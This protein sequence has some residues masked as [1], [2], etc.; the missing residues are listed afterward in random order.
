VRLF[1]ATIGFLIFAPTVVAFTVYV[2]LFVRSMLRNWTLEHL[3][4]LLFLWQTQIAA[5][6]AIA[7]ALIGSAVVLHQTA[8]VRRQ[9]DERRERRSAALWAVLPLVLMELIDYATSCAKILAGLLERSSTGVHVHQ[10]GLQ[11]PPL[12]DGL[13]DR[14]A[15]LIEAIESGHANPLIILVRRLQIQH[16]RAREIQRRA[17]DQHGSIVL[18][19]NLIHGLIGAAEIYA[20]CANLLSYA[21]GSVDIVAAI[22]PNDV[23]TALSALSLIAGD[24]SDIKEL[25][26]EIDRIAATDPNGG[27]PET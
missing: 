21:R 25:I 2:R 22:S 5:A 19:A 3:I 15:E 7:A 20:R 27:W 9:E 12:P 18:R 16:A 10:P 8:T 6:F 26:R 23:K 11:F 14:L 24:L 13:V 1:V 17:V 4:T